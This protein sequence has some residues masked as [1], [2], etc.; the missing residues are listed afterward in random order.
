MKRFPA[1]TL[2][3]LLLVSCSPKPEDV[4]FAAVRAY[5]AEHGISGRTKFMQIS[6]E[7]EWAW[8]VHTAHDDFSKRQGSYKLNGYYF[9][10]DKGTMKVV[11][12]ESSL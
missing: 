5:A 6:E 8:V 12:L 2:T 1:T 11:D 3:F 7:T 9:T 4:A 10:V